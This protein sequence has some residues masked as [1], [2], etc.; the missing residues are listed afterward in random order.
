M[1]R[2]SCRAAHGLR[3]LCAPLLVG[4]LVADW[5]TDGVTH[6]DHARIDVARTYPFQQDE[7]YIH[8]RGGMLVYSLKRWS[9]LQ[10]LLARA[11][12]AKWHKMTTCSHM[13]GPHG[14]FANS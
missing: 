1:A 7:N 12:R 9:A 14:N 4:K 10:R 13:R 11:V 2:S 6:L 8:D 5:M 3:E